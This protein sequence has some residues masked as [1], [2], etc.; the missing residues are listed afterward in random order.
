MQTGQVALIPL[1]ALRPEQLATLGAL[2]TTFRDEGAGLFLV[3]GAVRDLLLGREP[4]DLD[5]TTDAAI[6]TIRRAASRAGASAVYASNER[7]ATIG[8]HFGTATC[9]ITSF[10]GA[11]EAS[12]SAE[13]GLLADL[14]LRDFTINALALPVRAGRLDAAPLIDPHDGQTDLQQ[15]TLRGV[16]DPRARLGEDPLRALR[17]ARLAAELDFTIEP[18]TRAAVVAI[19]PRLADVSPERIG[20]ELSRLLVTDQVA[21]GLALLEH[22]ALL[23]VVLPDLV[24]LVTF[25]A[26]GSKDLWEHTRRVVAATP[27]DPLVRWAALLHDVAKPRTYSVAGGEVH[28]FGHEVAGARLARRLLTR[29]KFDRQTVAAVSR[30]VESHGRPAQYDASWTDGAVRRLM[31]DVEPWFEQLLALAR[32]DVTSARRG[33]RERAQARIAELAAHGARLI[34][35]QELAT[36]RSPLDGTALMALFARPPGPWIKPIKDYLRDLVIEGDLAP[37]DQERATMLAQ[38]WV[39]EHEPPVGGQHRER[40]ELT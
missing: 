22:L 21:A 35:E 32:A 10:R 40:E 34:A 37:D 2:A 39:A 23:P 36:L 25:A 13:A 1:D 24:P 30:L 31:L 3:G 20:A 17:A 6:E 28:F 33:V 4:P 18:A 11:V 9:E 16:R 5:L 7:F 14:G 15:R 27:P 19:A 29:L 12:Q 26:T 8:V 38:A